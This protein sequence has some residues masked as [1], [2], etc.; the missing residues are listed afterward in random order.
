MTFEETLKRELIKA[1]I[2]AYG[3]E[4]WTAKTDVEKSET[5]H[6]LLVAFLR[7]GRKA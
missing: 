4:S 2:E 3:A 6:D 5:L 1:Y 7:A